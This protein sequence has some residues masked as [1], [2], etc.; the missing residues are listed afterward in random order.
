KHEIGGC[1]KNSAVG[2]LRHFVYPLDI[3][4]VGINCFDR[5]VIPFVFGARVGVQWREANGYC[6]TAPAEYGSGIEL[7]FAL[8]ENRRGVFPGRNVEQAGS[9]IEGGVV[10]VRAALIAGINQDARG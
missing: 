5:A 9:W 6:G 10:P 8:R 2:D 4:R 3:A 7:L 1:C